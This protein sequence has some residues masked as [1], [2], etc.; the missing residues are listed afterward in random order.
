[1]NSFNVIE[2]FEEAGISYSES[3]K[4]ISTNWIGIN[5]PFCDDTS[6][7]CGVNIESKMFS[8]WRCSSKGGI[9]KL[10]M[11][12]ENKSYNQII[13][14]LNQ[15]TKKDKNHG[16]LTKRTKDDKPVH[17][18]IQDI[19]TKLTEC[20]KE[21]LKSRNFDPDFL[22]SRYKLRSG[23]PTSLYKHRII[24][25]YIVRGKTYTFTS[26]DV[27][28]QAKIKYLHCQIEQSILAPKELLFNG[29][30]CKDSVICLEGCTDVFRIGSGSVSLSGIQYTQKQLLVL[31]KFKQIFI[32]FDP[33]EQAQDQ[34]RKLSF[35]L[36]FCSSLVE[37][38]KVD[39]DLDPGDYSDEDVKH[40]KRYLFGRN[41]D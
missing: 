9:S 25:P 28:G 30:N 6:N 1:M 23:K 5:C 2:Y 26:R 16:N 10:I 7:H 18:L 39:T 37:I 24:I 13:P 11:E 29:D 31:S 17:E 19:S 34:A 8:C 41:Y 35:D 20:H 27:S 14:I 36:S 21:Y 3:G 4:N 15:F 12:I 22:E 32:L 40:L 38:I 33:E